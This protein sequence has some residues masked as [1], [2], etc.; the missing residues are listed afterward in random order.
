MMYRQQGEVVVMNHN[1]KMDINKTRV[2]TFN[3]QE[4]VL[5]DYRM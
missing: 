1:F 3:M 5:P 4:Y 2:F